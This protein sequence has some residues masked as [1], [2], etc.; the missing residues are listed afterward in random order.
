MGIGGLLMPKVV[1]SFLSLCLTYFAINPVFCDR[2]MAEPLVHTEETSPL[3]SPILTYRQNRIRFCPDEYS[4]SEDLY[5]A[6]DLLEGTRRLEQIRKCRTFAFFAWHR[7]TGNI[8]VSSNSCRLRWCPICAH[9]KAKQITFELEKHIRN[10]RNPK[11]L[12]LTQKHSNAPLS[13]QI[14]TLY[15]NF[16]KLRNS[17]FFKS[18]VSGGIWFF[19]IKKSDKTNQWHPHLHLLIDSEYMWQKDLS[20]L[21]LSI[22]LTSKVV[23]IR[24]IR[25]VKKS[26]EYIARYSSRP[27]NLASLEENDR[28][29][30]FKSLHGRRINGTF[31]NCRGLNLTSP[32]K[33]DHSEYVNLGSFDTIRKMIDKDISAKQI[34]K[35]WL[36]G[37]SIANP[38]LIVSEEKVCF[39]R[40]DKPWLH[41]SY[42]DFDW[43]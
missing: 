10:L 21:W 39:D 7:P 33:P 43:S 22:T 42:D 29:E 4:A 9:S 13:H 19:Q 40:L 34:W 18:K 3:H 14:T 38:R 6:S 11:F 8:R 41:F 32:P 28:M 37:D 17:K 23:D 5:H 26:A 24:A 25:D 30:L 36:R 20:D 16:T 31:G 2:P 35:A 27:S 1:G 15:G 12:T